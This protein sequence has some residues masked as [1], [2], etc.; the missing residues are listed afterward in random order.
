[1]VHLTLLYRYAWTHLCILH[2]HIFVNRDQNYFNKGFEES[3]SSISNQ[4]WKLQV[5]NQVNC[6]IA[7]RHLIQ[8][9]PIHNI[10]SYQQLQL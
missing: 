10:L 3:V 4:F 6:M 7:R 5:I 2:S 1:M 8:Y 9:M